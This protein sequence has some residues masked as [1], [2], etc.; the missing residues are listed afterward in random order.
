MRQS[1]A[2]ASS[3][4]IATIALSGLLL[5]A[6]TWGQTAP[7][8]PLSAAQ[9]ADA[10]QRSYGYERSQDHANALRALA[11]V[12]AANPDDY[13]VNLRLGW[14]SYL[15]GHHADATDHYA[16]AIR[17]APQSI[18]A[19][20]GRLL[21]LLAQE[22]YASAEAAALQ[23]VALDHYS[24]YGNLRLAH[25]LRMQGKLE[26]AER[27]A[28]KMAGAYPTDTQFLTELALID[29][30]RDDL[31]AASRRFAHILLL[32]PENPIARAELQDPE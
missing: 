9:I 15:A 32:D 19:K 28:A 14:L 12:H 25:A 26:Q 3:S 24:Y 7:P 22:R 23:I 29:V 16:S 20:L 6:T 5:S 1:P 30:A 10:Y 11:P 8:V 31:A 2:R 13:T 17:A 21:P 27:I 4:I 18:E